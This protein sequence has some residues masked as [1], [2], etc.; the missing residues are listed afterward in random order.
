LRASV[1][2]IP[3]FDLQ[4]DVEILTVVAVVAGV[5]KAAENAGRNPFPLALKAKVRS[6]RLGPLSLTVAKAPGVVGSFLLAR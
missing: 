5:G 3:I 1:T 2:S 4:F 6:G